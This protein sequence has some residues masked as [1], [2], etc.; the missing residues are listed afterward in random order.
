MAGVELL[1]EIVKQLSSSEDLTQR[2]QTRDRIRQ[3]LEDVDELLVVETNAHEDKFYD[4]LNSFQHV[5]E[6]ITD[7]KFRVNVLREGLSECKSLLRLKRDRI[8]RLATEHAEHVE[9]LKLLDQIEDIKK[10]PEKVDEMLRAKDY[11]NGA[12]LL[13]E[14]TTALEGESLG[15]VRALHD[16][17]RKLIDRMQ[18]MRGIIIA[19]LH[20]HIYLKPRLPGSA[21]AS[22]SSAPVG[23]G[24]GA[25]PGVG[26]PEPF[27]HLTHGIEALGVLGVL[28]EAI[29]ALCTSLK[30]KLS[31]LVEQAV[32]QARTCYA[33]DVGTPAV[34]ADQSGP[35][36]LHQFL[37]G[38]YDRMFRVFVCHAHLLSVIRALPDGEKMLTSDATQGTPQYSEHTVWDAIQMEVQLLL[39]QYLDLDESVLVDNSYG[40]GGSKRKHARH[41]SGSGTAGTSGDPSAH[42]SG[43]AV[44]LF[45]F[46]NSLNSMTET[47]AKTELAVSS[48]APDGTAAEYLFAGGAG[49]GISPGATRGPG[50]H[51][52]EPS[53]MNVT[54][55]YK[56]TV[57]F[58]GEMDELLTEAKQLHPT[59]CGQ[60]SLNM[61]LREF[62]SSF[63]QQS[64]LP[65]I[66][67]EIAVLLKT[68][69]ETADKPRDDHSIPDAPQ[70]L[71]RSTYDI[72]EA[73]GQLC[74]LFL[75]LPDLSNAF[76][77]LLENLLHRYTAMCTSRFKSF[78][79]RPGTSSG[80][81]NQTHKDKGKREQSL[82]K[83]ATWQ[84]LPKL[85][86]AIEALDCW[87]AHTSATTATS[88]DSPGRDRQRAKTARESKL[89][90]RQVTSAGPLEKGDVMTDMHMVKCVAHLHESTCW[91]ANQID[92]VA[93]CLKSRDH[94]GL[95][96]IWTIV[97]PV[98]EENLNHTAHVDGDAAA[99]AIVSVADQTQVDNIQQLAA[100]LMTSS[101]TCLVTLRLDLRLHCL[102]YLLPAI[103][104]SSYVCTAEQIEEADAQ[105]VSLCKDILSF[106]ETL[107]V[108]LLPGN[109]EI[110]FGDIGSFL[111]FVLIKELPAIKKVNDLGVM[112]MCRS[113][114]ALQQT[115][116]TISRPSCAN[117]LD[118]AMQYY[119]L[120]N[121]QPEQVLEGI[122]ISGKVFTEDEYK[123]V[124]DLIEASQTVQS[125]ASHQAVLKQLVEV[126]HELV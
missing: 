70:V 8:H 55:V 126:F 62:V 86:D 61:S 32:A 42:G 82:V 93:R 33:A 7:C 75:D 68:L 31:L 14:T 78:V 66:Q 118:V 117:V 21:S 50:R 112:R 63:L 35:T 72:H 19:E 49:H 109:Y 45:T 15:Q 29:A 39:C 110:V 40:F 43:S 89:L 22:S 98:L 81:R 60:S 99:D 104:K 101:N 16:L 122:V 91:L 116:R 17:H 5:S 1:G 77:S 124:L 108:S 83:S 94:V 2:E 107:S 84:A 9:T 20:N 52:C 114:F 111:S 102:Y 92:T 46:A 74:G 103:R 95:A 69:V 53:P 113:I 34:A 65:L 25:T 64:F 54:G 115:L 11:V 67:T 100:D 87:N 41:A 36:L 125:A 88:P 24:G 121:L 73:T 96:R 38:L 26:S 13:V 79:V 106:D 44:P 51:L 56:P 59:T 71:F 6:T 85:R 47:A 90:M 80:K 27:G 37:T 58:V 28:P 119:E 12:R 3:Q 30:P 105:V 4:A 48:T 76:L 123:A 57:L 120:L 18:K 97:G 10:V 23:K